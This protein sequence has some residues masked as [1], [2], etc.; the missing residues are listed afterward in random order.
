MCSGEMLVEG[1]VSRGVITAASLK[2]PQHLLDQLIGAIASLPRCKPQ[3]EGTLP[4]GA[5]QVRL[6]CGARRHAVVPIKWRR[7]I[8]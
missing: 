3:C 1:M 5:R 6:E 8:E 4:P 7:E 2:A